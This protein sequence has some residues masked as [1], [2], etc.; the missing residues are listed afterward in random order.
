[1]NIILKIPFMP[2]QPRNVPTHLDSN[3]MLWIALTLLLVQRE[4][5]LAESGIIIPETGECLLSNY[6]RSTQVLKSTEE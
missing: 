5:R 4:V 3:S 2:F 1:M 6:G